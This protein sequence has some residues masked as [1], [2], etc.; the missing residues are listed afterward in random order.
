[1]TITD[2]LNL[3]ALPAWHARPGVLAR[4]VADLIA[5]EVGHLRPGG[6]H[7][8]ER[9]WPDDLGL[10]EE[11]LG[12][13]SLELLAVA[14]ALSEALHLHESGLEDLLLAHRRIGEWVDI[15]A[16]GLAEFDALLTFRTSGS[17]GTAKPCTHALATLQQEVDHLQTLTAGTRR[18]LS[19][20]P[21]HHIYG[22]LFTVLL[23][24]RLGCEDVQD[25]RRQ[26]PASLAQWLR[27][28]DLVVGH[29]AHWALV[30]RHAGRL[31]AGVRGVTSTAPCPDAL[32]DGLQAIGLECLTQVY[33]SSETAGIGTR[34]A[35]AAPFR[36]MPHWLREDGGS[37]RLLRLD[38]DG[39]R[40]A[41]TVQDRLEW[42]TAQEFT[43]RGRLDDAVQVGGNNVFPSH[44]REVLVAHPLV[45]EAV[46]RLMTPEEGSRLKAFVVAVP[47]VDPHTLR[48]EL[49]S[50]CET[51]LGAPSRPKAYTFGEHLPLTP[52][53]KAAD[54]PLSPQTAAA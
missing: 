42:H 9:P 33:G 41:H 35:A 25:I 24:A 13:D 4:V 44:V 2:P 23:P 30:A 5:A 21:A 16:R 38:P 19:A 36:L 7:L 52:L 40:H 8:P 3:S 31:T 26:T 17:T 50:W 27:S 12:L 10:G 28:G 15:A 20:V 22:F 53:G 39:G 11:G 6:S 32:A 49:W 45:A 37:G 48:A 14:S 43:V 46:V 1:M 51:R 47:G 54:W 29:P 34:N 18:V